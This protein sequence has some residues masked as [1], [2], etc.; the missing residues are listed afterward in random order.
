MVG[1]FLESVYVFDG[2]FFCPHCIIEELATPA[3]ITACY[4]RDLLSLRDELIFWARVR[5]VDLADSTSYDSSD[6][7]VV[8]PNIGLSIG[9]DVRVKC[10]ACDWYLFGPM[11]VDGIAASAYESVLDAW[12]N[13]AFRV[14]DTDDATVAGY[15][16]ANAKSTSSPIVNILLIEKSPVFRELRRTL[17]VY[18]DETWR[19]LEPD[20]C[21]PEELGIPVSVTAIVFH[22]NPE[23]LARA[24]KRGLDH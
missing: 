11:D 8:I 4:D 20:E 2:Q 3:Q 24:I 16:R 22:A 14:I 10:H 18:A 9:G 13:V 1:T 19:I 21:V 7:P 5:N 6:F 12:Q 23:S 17:A 15:T